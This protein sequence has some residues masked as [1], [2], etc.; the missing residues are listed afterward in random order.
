MVSKIK[1]RDMIFQFLRNYGRTKVIIGY[2]V[3]VSAL[4]ASTAWNFDWDM[5]DGGRF[6]FAFI[7]TSISVLSLI[8]LVVFTIPVCQYLKGTTKNDFA[9]RKDDVMDEYYIPFFEKAFQKLDLEN[10]SI[11]TSY[12]AI[13]GTLLI[14]NE[15][16]NNLHAVQYMM[17][18]A[19]KHNG[20]EFLDGLIKNLGLLIDDLLYVMDSHLVMRDDTQLTINRFYKEPYPNPNYNEDLDKYNK[21]VR[22]ISDLTFEMTRILNLILDIMRRHKT[23]FMFEVGSLSIYECS[24]KSLKYR[25]EE[26]SE[27][28]YPG[29]QKFLEIR[30]SRDLY[31]DACTD[32]DLQN[33]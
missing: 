10:Y 15:Q 9:I 29:L 8:F 32:L 33:L 20:Q 31:M 25:K 23:G 3:L 21:I 24:S 26:I 5:R 22:L 30:S 13:Q 19:V 6:H 7:P 2:F 18:R 16:Y 1:L 17:N 27:S 4:F 11:W 12:I 28:P 14:T